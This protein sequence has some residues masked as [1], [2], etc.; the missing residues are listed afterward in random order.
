MRLKKSS[1]SS[2]VF[3]IGPSESPPRDPVPPVAGSR[4][5]ERLSEFR[6]VLV[7][8][9]E[10]TG[11]PQN[12]RPAGDSDVLPSDGKSVGSFLTLFVDKYRFV[13][14]ETPLPRW[15][16]CSSGRHTPEGLFRLESRGRTSRVSELASGSD[17]L[18]GAASWHGTDSLMPRLGFGPERKVLL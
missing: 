2:E 15:L 17:I 3:D 11:E 13:S 5:S 12:V 4:N 14:D 9:G 1:E 16:R 18:Y 7:C 10:T 6:F 8:L